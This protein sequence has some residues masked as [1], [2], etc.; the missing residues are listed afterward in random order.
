MSPYRNN[1]MTNRE[2][3]QS[4]V[5]SIAAIDAE[6]KHVG[7]LRYSYETTRADRLKVLFDRQNQLLD[8]LR[9]G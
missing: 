2:Y 4:L 5:S 7:T 6:I 3:K 8:R 9:N 1:A